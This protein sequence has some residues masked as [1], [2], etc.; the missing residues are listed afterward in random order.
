MEKILVDPKSEISYSEKQRTSF[1]VE[2]NN[3]ESRLTYPEKRIQPE[4]NLFLNINPDTKGYVAQGQYKWASNTSHLLHD[5]LCD[6]FVL[7]KLTGSRD[8][9]HAPTN[10]SNQIISHLNSN[11]IL[12]ESDNL[13]DSENKY[14]YLEIGSETS[15]RFSGHQHSYITNLMR[16]TLK[17]LMVSDPRLPK[18]IIIKREIGGS[19]PDKNRN[20]SDLTSFVDGLSAFG[21]DFTVIGLSNLSLS[22][23]IAYFFNAEKIISVHGAGLAWLNFCKE[24]TKIIEII[25]PYF[26][27]GDYLKHDFWV[28]SHQHGLDYAALYLDKVVGDIESGYHF[29]VIVPVNCIVELLRN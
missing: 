5:V 29:D 4:I 27:H 21:Y 8:L 14:S 6:H 16:E 24:N 2:G 15:W 19:H 18:N 17:G 3:L 11:L 25:P 10:L 28:I 13:D 12:G 7:R 23:Q 20:I 22:E 26:K 9:I 1:Y